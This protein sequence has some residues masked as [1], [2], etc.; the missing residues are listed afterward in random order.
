MNGQII[1]TLL[2][3]TIGGA[4]FISQRLR[5]QEPASTGDFHPL[6]LVPADAAS[7]DASGAGDG[8]AQQ[9]ERVKNHDSAASTVEEG[10]HSPLVQKALGSL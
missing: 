8:K 10:S 3:A 1:Q 5:A 4:A 6:T 7:S 2:A 9:G